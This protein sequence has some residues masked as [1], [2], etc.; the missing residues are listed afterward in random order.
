MTIEHDANADGIADVDTRRNAVSEVEQ[1]SLQSS[2][3]NLEVLLE[4]FS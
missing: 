4:V 1:Q 3:Q 2:L